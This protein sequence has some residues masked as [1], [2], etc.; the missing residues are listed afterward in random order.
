MKIAARRVES[1]KRKTTAK[2]S[3]R[4]RATT[5]ER[6]WTAVCKPFA[7]MGRILRRIWNRIARID[8]IALV[9]TTLLVSII[10]L[11]SMLIIDIL[12]CRKSPVI[13]IADPAAASSVQT[14][15]NDVRRVRPRPVALPIARDENTGKF[16]AE[17]VQVVPARECATTLRQTAR[18]NDKMYGDIIIDSRGAATM[19][20]RGAQIQGNLYL[21]N[22]RKFILPCDIHIDGNL[23]LRD[24][25]MMQFCGDFTITGNIYVSPR[26]SF[27]P[28]PR[29]ARL[30]GQVI[31]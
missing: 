8:L 29:T 24:V 21:Q 18:Q 6:I 20:T 16:R 13:V 23:F 11:F 26:S 1:R 15:K 2:K 19:L 14:S 27:G 22:M 4:N 7:A 3:R 31:L 17:P 30:G 5:W 10:V 25:N 12:N 28:I 9:N